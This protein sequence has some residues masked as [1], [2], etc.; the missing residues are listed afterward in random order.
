M[1]SSV[2]PIDEMIKKM[3]EIVSNLE[4]NHK[5]LKIV[6]FNITIAKL[7]KDIRLLNKCAEKILDMH[8][9]YEIIHALKGITRRI[10]IIKDNNKKTDI[11]V[12]IAHESKN[13]ADT[14]QL[15]DM[16]AIEEQDKHLESISKAVQRL[17]GVSLNIGRE[18]T[19][20]TEIITDV[21]VD[22]ENADAKL[23]TVNSLTKK[24]S[25]N[26]RNN[27]YCYFIVF[28]IIV[29]IILILLVIAIP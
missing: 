26:I 25:L 24:L 4:L 16:K 20:Q 17:H 7:E 1:D 5:T 18:L 29:L 2:D 10:N 14:R 23:N 22:I 19:E 13:E 21:T 27:S 12:P 28:L 11:F 9:K 15:L 3:N 6:Q 8:E